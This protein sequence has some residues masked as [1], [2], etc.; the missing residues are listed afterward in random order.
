M[1]LFQPCHKISLFRQRSFPLQVFFARLDQS[2]G[3]AILIATM[4]FYSRCGYF[5]IG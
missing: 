5:T 4:Q 1:Y 2:G 3:E